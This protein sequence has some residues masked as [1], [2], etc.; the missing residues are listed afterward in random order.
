MPTFHFAGLDEDWGFP[1]LLHLR[2]LDIIL[3][4]RAVMSVKDLQQKLHNILAS[5]TSLAL[6]HIRLILDLPRLYLEKMNTV[7]DRAQYADLHAVLARPI[8]AS[9]HRVTVVLHD[10]RVKTSIPADHLA[11]E[12]LGFLHALFAPWCVRG[13]V[14]LACTIR[15]SNMFT[16]ALVY[17]L[18]GLHWLKW[19]QIPLGKAPSLLWDASGVLSG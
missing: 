7:T 11:L 4:I 13:I 18:K 1:Q 3:E 14:S 16:H 10:S 12:L 15:R 6:E 19:I 17:D 9:L 5:L 2:T 8:F